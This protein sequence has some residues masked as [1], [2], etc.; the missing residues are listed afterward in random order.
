MSEHEPTYSPAQIREAIREEFMSILRPSVGM[1]VVVGAL[2]GW[3]G[4]P[5]HGI[6]DG[7]GIGIA[8]A[9]L[10]FVGFFFLGWCYREGARATSGMSRM[11]S[12]P[13]GELLLQRVLGVGLNVVVGLVKGP[14]MFLLLLYRLWQLRKY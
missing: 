4:L 8:A 14:Y 7:V 3:R 12:G 10:A 11:S 2:L 6:S 13:T 5:Q 1:G 9:I